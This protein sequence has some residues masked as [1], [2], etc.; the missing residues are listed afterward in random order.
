MFVS[1]ISRNSNAL[2]FFTILASASTSFFVLNTLVKVIFDPTLLK[3][4]L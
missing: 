2:F 1:V 3:T 4:R